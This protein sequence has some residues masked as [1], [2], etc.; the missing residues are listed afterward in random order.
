VLLGAVLLTNLNKMKQYK[1]TGLFKSA[2]G[3]IYQIEVRCN[4]FLQAFFL[5]TADA[6][7]SGRHYQL[8]SIMDENMKEKMV[9]DIIKCG[10]LLS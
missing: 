8:H 1:Y 6:I 3:H 2:E 10:A 5:L 7:R 9:D 4:G